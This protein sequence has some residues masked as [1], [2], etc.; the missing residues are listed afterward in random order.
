MRVLAVP[1]AILVAAPLAARSQ[2]AAAPPA[3]PPVQWKA[4]VKAG[5][6][7]TS[8]NSETTTV[9]GAANVS[10][11]DA[12][13]KAALE[14]V[15]AYGQSGLFVASDTNGNGVIDRGEYHRN[16]QTT[17]N[18]WNVK[19]RYDRFITAHQ[20]LFAAAS[21][22]ADEIAGKNLVAGGQAGY[23]IKLL[24]TDVQE[25]IGELG[26]DFSYEEYQA[27]GVKPN[28]IHSGRAFLGETLKLSSTAGLV[29]SVEA[30]ANLNT[31]K[32][33]P[34]ARAADPTKKVTAF[35]DLRV[36][37]KLALTAAI[38]SNVS[39]SVGFLLKY[40]R[41]PAPLPQISG[42]PAFGFPAFAKEVDTVT[43]AALIVTFM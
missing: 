40:D 32:N 29:A 37:G 28:E 6:V 42:A 11:T 35:E 2:E 4:Q 3:P 24:K 13:N 33:A 27:T 41:N 43:D 25:L 23:A 20:G 26:Y 31:E 21:V 15:V 10:R 1:L 5:L 9:T 12:A 14:G 38:R 7:S 17:V 36:N 39:L 34:N 18:N 30:L 19:A 16:T 8:G 22:G